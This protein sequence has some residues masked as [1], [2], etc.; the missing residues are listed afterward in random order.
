MGQEGLSL[1]G[2]RVKTFLLNYADFDHQINT[3]NANQPLSEE[4][5]ARAK[6]DVTE[7]LLRG[8]GALHGSAG[9]CE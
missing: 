9:P 8:I 1:S 4:Q 3:L 2:K 5:F 7:T 6:Q